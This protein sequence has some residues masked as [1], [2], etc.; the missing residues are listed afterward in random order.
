MKPDPN[1][2]VRS[3]IAGNCAL[4]HAFEPRRLADILHWTN[5]D[6]AAVI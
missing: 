6:K 5:E 3:L 1:G 4:C 2:L